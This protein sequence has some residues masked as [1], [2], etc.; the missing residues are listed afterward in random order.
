MEAL[1][2]RKST[3]SSGNG[4]ECVEVG[5]GSGVVAVRDTQDRHGSA[6]AFIPAAWR[7]FTDQVKRS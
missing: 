6:L 4:A 1:D 7:R 3:Y 2:W 5:N